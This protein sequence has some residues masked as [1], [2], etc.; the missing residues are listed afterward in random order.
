MSEWVDNYEHRVD[1]NRSPRALELLELLEYEYIGMYGEPD[2]D[3]DGGLQRAYGAH[4]DTV[5]ALYRKK[6]VGIAGVVLEEL[7]GR[8]VATLHRMF[9]IYPMRGR[10]IASG[11][12]RECEIGAKGLGA[13]ALY[14]ETGVT[15]TSA[16]ALYRS[17]GYQPVDPFGFYADQ[18]TSIF[19]G[20][21][22]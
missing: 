7:N 3:P 13:K 4:G 10:G 11:L 20:K 6:A 14:L 5:L 1:P 17:H 8:K 15:Q 18:P 22:L 9:V 16:I 19:L 2:P 12:L 21:A